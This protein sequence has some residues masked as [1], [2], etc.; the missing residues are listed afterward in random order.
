MRLFVCSQ[1]KP[2]RD[3]LLPGLADLRALTHLRLVFH[4]DAWIDFKSELGPLDGEAA[5][6]DAF[7]DAVRPASFASF[8]FAFAARALAD[9]LP[10]LRYCFLATSG[11]VTEV[12]ESDGPDTVA[13]RWRASWAWRIAA[14]GGLVELQDDVAESVIEREG[15]ALSTE[16]QVGDPPPPGP[17][18]RNF[19]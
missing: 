7:L 12:V 15:L 5:E 17:A 16:E 2:Q 3:T 18:R 14:G 9:A 19:H 11:R 1:L 6:D 13:E 4:C 10:R 8:A